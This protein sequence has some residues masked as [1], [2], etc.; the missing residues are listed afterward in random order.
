M[1]SSF[2]NK[3]TY[4]IHILFQVKFSE[5]LTNFYTTEGEKIEK[6]EKD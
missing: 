5:M 4:Y 2:R 6:I 1:A 3:F